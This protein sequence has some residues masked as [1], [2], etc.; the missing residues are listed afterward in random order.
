MFQFLP[1]MHSMRASV[2]ACTIEIIRVFKFHDTTAFYE[3]GDYN[4]TLYVDV[5][6]QANWRDI[7]HI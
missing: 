6:V 4:Y 7:K 5:D 1:R 3:Y 2:C